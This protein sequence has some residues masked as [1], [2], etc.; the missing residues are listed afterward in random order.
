MSVGEPSGGPSRAKLLGFGLIGVGVVA[1]GFGTVTL[2]SEDESPSA[3]APPK[4]SQVQPPP[5]QTPPETSV[6]APPPPP[7]VTPPPRTSS[8]EPPTTSQ[9]PPTTSEQAPDRPDQKIVVRVFNN[10]TISGLAHRAAEDFKRS[11]Y[12][13]PEVGNYA[14][15]TVPTTT[16]YYRPGTSEE[17]LAEEVAAY[18]GAEAKP[19]FPE[20]ERSGDGIIAIITNDYQGPSKVK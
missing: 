4:T 17:K 12:E 9:R 10:S 1:A 14:R 13:V 6:L 15:T 16:F 3:A 7:E 11:G 2:L 20:I 5:A 18:F 19:R 8:A